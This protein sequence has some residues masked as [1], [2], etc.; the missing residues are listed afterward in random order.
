MIA[1]DPLCG[2]GGKDVVED[3]VKVQMIE[4]GEIRCGPR[5]NEAREHT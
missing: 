3:A 1:S 4:P 2:L 5:V